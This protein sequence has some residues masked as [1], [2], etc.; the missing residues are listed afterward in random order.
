MK[1]KQVNI[2]TEAEPEC[3]KIGGYRE[4][5]TVDKVFELLHEYQDL[6]PTKFMDLKGIIR[7]LRVMKITLKPDTK[8]VKQRPSF[9][10]PKYKEKV[11]LELDKIL[12][13]GIIEPVEESNWVSPMVVQE[14][15][16]KDG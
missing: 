15:K 7:D 12:V 11:R 6:F 4:N 2:G 3:A 16:Q 1:T 9:L 13:A 10:N 5:T 8:R 14:K